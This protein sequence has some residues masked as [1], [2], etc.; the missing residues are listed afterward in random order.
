MKQ[1]RESKNKQRRKVYGYGQEGKLK[2]LKDLNTELNKEL[3]NLC[4][5][6][7]YEKRNSR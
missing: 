2:K 4:Y 3:K 1:F 5:G 7:D 6:K